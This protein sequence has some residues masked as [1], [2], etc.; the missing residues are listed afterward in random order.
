MDAREAGAGGQGHAGVSAMS[1]PAGTSNRGPEQRMQLL[2]ARIA[3]H[4][5]DIASRFALAELVASQGQYERAKQAYLDILHRDPT[6]YLT[7]NNLANLLY[8]AGFTSAARTA[9]QAAI[10]HHPE[11]P[12]AYTNLA[13]LLFYKGE[14][15]EA[16]AHYHTALR[17]S[18]GHV[19]AHQGLAVLYHKIGNEA[20]AGQHRDLAYGQHPL[21]TCS[22]AGTGPAVPM[23]VLTSA[24][25]GTLPWRTL[26]DNHLFQATT[27]AVEYLR[28]DQPLPAHAIILNAIG[29]ADICRGALTAAIALLTTTRAPVINP[30]ASVLATGR[31]DNAARLRSIPGVI[32]PHMAIIPRA[33]LLAEGAA[34]PG[35]I[36]G[37]RFPFLVRSL[38][39]QTGHH[40]TLVEQPDAL[41]Q[42][43]DALPGSELLAIEYLDARGTDGK[44]RKY[45]VM[46][47]DGRLYPLHLA[48]A[49]NWKVH[50]FSAQM[51]GHRVHQAEEAAFLTDMAQVLGAQAIAAL[52]RIRDAL[53]LD[54][55][56]IDF[57]CRANGEIVVFEANATMLI[58]RPWADAQF[59]Y[60]RP[61]A[62]AALAAART[63]LRS[64]SGASRHG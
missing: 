60:R 63:M 32:T 3:A 57:F 43:V 45:R 25:G 53:A 6:H 21:E 2:E 31:L 58:G 51:T 24:I 49:D 37:L 1:G 8:E 7:L 38:G 41:R 56:G 40:F 36:A 23:L 64:R 59:E 48:I 39:F 46:F 61:A 34:V 26:V 9:Y 30:P 54:Y 35:A 14:V 5:D 33:S 17:L 62:A 11:K 28:A 15:D 22:Y 18:P 4:P 42:A 50:Y 52:E 29:D 12:V 44:A 20:Q 13:N 10:H 16:M 19:K 27:A 47:I 55:C